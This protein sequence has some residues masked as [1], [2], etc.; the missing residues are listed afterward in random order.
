MCAG[1]IIALVFCSGLIT[2]SIILGLCS[3]LI[4]ISIIDLY[5]RLIQFLSK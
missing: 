3:G 5:R 1:C 2:I 4:T